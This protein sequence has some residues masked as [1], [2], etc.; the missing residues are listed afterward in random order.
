VKFFIAVF[1]TAMRE[2][3]V[4]EPPAASETLTDGVDGRGNGDHKSG[5]VPGLHPDVA[6]AIWVRPALTI[7]AMDSPATTPDCASRRYP[8]T[9]RLITSPPHN[10]RRS[11]TT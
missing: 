3:V 8:V 11:P 2:A 7:S 5:F 1:E 9:A 10:A 4:D 6:E